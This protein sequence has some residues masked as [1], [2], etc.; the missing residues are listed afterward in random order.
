MKSIQNDS[1]NRGNKGDIDGGDKI[2]HKK[3]EILNANES[4]LGSKKYGLN[5][6]FN[7]NLNTAQSH[8]ENDFKDGMKNSPR[9]SNTS[10]RNKITALDKDTKRSH[11]KDTSW[12]GVAGWYGAYL[13]GNDTYQSEVI[14]PNLERL[15][16][17]YSPISPFGKNAGQ[18]NT[19]RKLIDVACGQGYF[20]YLAS[21]LNFDVT[22]VD[23][24]PELIE[25]AKKTKPRTNNSERHLPDQGR[26]YPEFFVA[27]AHDM[28]ILK[29]GTFETATCILALQNI[30]ELDQTFAEVARLLKKGGRLIFVMNHPSFRVPQF[31]D[32]YFDTKKGTQSRIVSKYMQ[33]TSIKIDMNPGVTNPRQKKITMSFHRPLQLF[34]KFLSKNGFVVSRLEEW[35]SHKKT[36]AGPRKA[37]EDLARKEI[38]M[39]IA[40]EATLL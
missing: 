18:K 30:R 2:H 37:A 26:M 22:G 27:P 33:E 28:G 9:L 3:D 16:N 7:R 24:A 13:G 25:A 23:I 4:R 20:S 15:L 31:S 40:I 5:K 32:W 38:P 21:A 11:S 19:E 29:S 1:P 12:G 6:G 34:I 39:F 8:L 35:C 17:T 36:G 10:R 14:W